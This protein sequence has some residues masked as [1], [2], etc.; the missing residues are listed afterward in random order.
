[1]PTYTV[2]YSGV[3]LTPDQKD[4][5]AQDITKT[6]NSETGAN[7]YFAQVIFYEVAFGNHYMGGKPVAEPQLFLHGQI[8]AGRTPEV[9]HKLILGLKD[10]LVSVSGLDSMHIWVYLVDLDP[11]QMI[12]FGE[13]LPK[14]GKEAE[15]FACLAPRLKEKLAAMEK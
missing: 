2:N 10:A 5:I 13:I 12:E 7:R 3:E 15:W 8:R 11:S 9:K 1:M 6:H 14:S 4:R